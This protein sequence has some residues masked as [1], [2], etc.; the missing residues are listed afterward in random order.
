MERLA[1]GDGLLPAIAFKTPKTL[2]FFPAQERFS[3]FFDRLSCFMNRPLIAVTLA[4]QRP[5]HSHLLNLNG[6]KEN[7]R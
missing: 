5:D 4:Y 3:N 2:H 7:P 1:R 6:K